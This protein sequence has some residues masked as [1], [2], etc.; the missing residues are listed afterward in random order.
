MNAMTDG[1]IY[2]VLYG[3]LLSFAVGPVFF[4]LIETAI[5]KG[6][7]AAIFFDLGAISADIV[8]III[9]FFS[10]NKILEKI[11][12]DPALLIFG[13]VVLIAYGVITY[14]RVNNSIF[15][16]M[17]EYYT[18]AVKGKFRNLFFKGFFL[19]FVNF[20]VLIGWIATLVM[21]NAL[22]T[23]DT[24]VFWFLATVLIT[25]F[26]TDLIKITLAKRVMRRLSGRLIFKTK[27]WVS[28]LIVIFGIFLLIQGIFPQG[29]E[30]GLDT[31][32]GQSHPLD[33]PIPPVIKE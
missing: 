10:T 14:I 31:I 4:T 33:K 2:A 6:I 9:A 26:T 12:H 32:P 27:Q 25:F 5:S 11:Q 28:I 8:F 3:F 16:I 24:G 7:R 17:R 23:T 29:L 15:K 21:A 19:N 30:A 1:L 18:K 13:G 22:T 20:G